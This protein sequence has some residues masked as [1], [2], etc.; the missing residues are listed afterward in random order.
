MDKVH[1]SHCSG[2]WRGPSSCIS[3]V[4]F[5]PIFVSSRFALNA[6]ATPEMLEYCRNLTKLPFAAA[7]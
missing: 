4:F 6:A 2:H 3:R 5:L 1:G 7:D